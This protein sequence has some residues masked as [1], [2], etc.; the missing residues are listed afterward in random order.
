MQFIQFDLWIQIQ[1]QYNLKSVSI[2]FNF[3]TNQ[4]TNRIYRVILTTMCSTAIYY[5]DSRLDSEKK[6][7]R[8]YT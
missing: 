2:A 5:L 6:E 3:V 8:K 7:L 4:D 1:N